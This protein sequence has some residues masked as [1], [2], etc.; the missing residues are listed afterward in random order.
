[1]NSILKALCRTEPSR[2]TVMFEG[3][4]GVSKNSRAYYRPQAVGS[5]YED[6]HKT[7]TQR[8]EAP[9]RVLQIRAWKKVVIRL[10]GAVH[11][12]LA[13]PGNP[14]GPPASAKPSTARLKRA[15]AGRALG[16]P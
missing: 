1:M 9:S 6:T 8:S 7:D 11:R 14:Y 4:V 3:Y 10:T 15:N 5:H 2:E 12:S 13:L 16:I